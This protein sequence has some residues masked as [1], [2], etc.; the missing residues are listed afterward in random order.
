M[1]F[2]TSRHAFMTT[3]WFK[4][5]MKAGK[6]PNGWID[7]LFW[8]VKHDKLGSPTKWRSFYGEMI[9]I[10]GWF[11]SGHVWLP[12]D[13]GKVTITPL[14]WMGTGKKQNVITSEAEISE[15][16]EGLFFRNHVLT[17]VIAFIPGPW[18]H[19]LTRIKQCPHDPLLVDGY[20]DW[21]I[22]PGF[23]DDFEPSWGDKE[24]LGA[25]HRF[26]PF[27]Q[28]ALEV[29]TTELPNRSNA[30]HQHAHV[31]YM[32]HA[33]PK[34]VPSIMQRFVTYLRRPKVSQ[35]W[36]G[37]S[38]AGSFSDHLILN[39]SWLDPLLIAVAASSKH[40]KTHQHIQEETQPK[41]QGISME[42]HTESHEL[43]S[44]YL[45]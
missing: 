34:H 2:S 12:E 4:D 21:G 6:P 40:L 18:P 44:G 14:K 33:R 22:I 27:G 43:P 29:Q 30:W 16:I 38:C 28:K 41:S 8:V 45:T 31:P 19:W 42:T 9:K 37:P 32:S 26:V 39:P 1:G 7:K 13:N 17:G 10:D 5:T 15:G 25:W 23:A 11:S 20:N 3:G 24:R 36:V 35:V